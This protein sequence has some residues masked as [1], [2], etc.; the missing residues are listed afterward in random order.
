MESYTKLL[1]ICINDLSKSFEWKVLKSQE[2]EMTMRDL[3]KEIKQKSLQQISSIKTCFFNYID[4]S[5][6]IDYYFDLQPFYFYNDPS[7]MQIFV[8][9]ANNKTLAID[10]SPKDCILDIKT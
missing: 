7:I 6:M 2:D 9:A 3:I 8:K 10:C 1:F 5:N 4:Y